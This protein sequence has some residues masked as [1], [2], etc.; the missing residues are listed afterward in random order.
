MGEGVGLTGVLGRQQAG[1][2]CSHVLLLSILLIVAE[3]EAGGR[4]M[5]G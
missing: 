1:D 5:Y 4:R 3:G 2:A